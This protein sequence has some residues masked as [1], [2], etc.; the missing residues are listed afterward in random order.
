M[1][2]TRLAMDDQWTNDGND[3]ISLSEN[4]GIKLQELLQAGPPPEGDRL[5]EPLENLRTQQSGV[6]TG[7]VRRLYISHFLSMWNS[8][9]FEF[10][11]VLFIAKIFPGT[12]LPVSIYAVVRS[13]AAIV[14][15]PKIGSYIDVNE[16]LKVVRLSIGKSTLQTRR[17]GIQV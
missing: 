4:D 10:G 9:F 17:H 15:S 5:P 2:L 11:A 6:P 12:L 14:L 13:A 8:R 1:D 7:I 3:S 16:R